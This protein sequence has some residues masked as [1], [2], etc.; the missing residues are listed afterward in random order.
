MNQK[1]KSSTLVPRRAKRSD[2]DHTLS[3]CSILHRTQKA[4]RFTKVTAIKEAQEEL[5]SEPY[6]GQEEY[7]KQH[8]RQR[9]PERQ[10]PLG[11]SRIGEVEDAR[12]RVL[13]KRRGVFYAKSCRAIR[14][15][16]CILARP[17]LRRRT[18]A[19]ACRTQCSVVCKSYNN[20]R[21]RSDHLKLVEP[22]CNFHHH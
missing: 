10:R 16:Y 6:E 9:P 19:P 14:L 8:E 5:Q 12:G 1:P 7:E 3:P 17:E 22:R 15:C 21:W 18:A 11:P 2:L 4:P 20:R 13:D